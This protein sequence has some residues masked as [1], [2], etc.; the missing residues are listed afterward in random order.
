M[1]TSIVLPTSFPFLSLLLNA[2]PR[3]N[4]TTHYHSLIVLPLNFALISYLPCIAA[5]ILSF[6]APLSFTLLHPHHN[7]SIPT[8]VVLREARNTHI[9]LPEQ[10][11]RAKRHK[12]CVHEGDECGARRPAEVTPAV[13]VDLYTRYCLSVSLLEMGVLGL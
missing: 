7:R 9:R 5:L 11:P 3:T 12:T 4:T 6:W 13:L 1:Y 2:F 8:H 10:I